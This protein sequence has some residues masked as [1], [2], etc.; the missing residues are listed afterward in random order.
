MLAMRYSNRSHDEI[1]AALALRLALAAGA[2]SIVSTLAFAACLRAQER[3]RQALGDQVDR[4][5]GATRRPPDTEPELAELV[6]RVN[7]T[8]ATA[9][10][11]LTAARHVVSEPGAA[12]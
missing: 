12:R 1:M 10:V 5:L 6:D 9:L 3:R 7:Q 2:A 4:A 11:E 8:S